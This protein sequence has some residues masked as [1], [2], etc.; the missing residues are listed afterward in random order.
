VVLP[1]ELQLSYVDKDGN[2]GTKTV[3][4]KDRSDYYLLTAGN[5]HVADELVV[6]A[7]LLA[8]R[9]EDKNVKDGVEKNDIVKSLIQLGKDNTMMSFRGCSADQYLVTVL[10][11]VALNAQR[12]NKFTESYSYMQKTISNQR[13]S[14]SGVDNDEEAVN[15]TKF[16]Q[17]YNMASKMIQVLS[18][19]YDRLINQT[20]V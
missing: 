20:G 18:E 8:T 13:L 6:D 17:Q 1:P 5:V 2:P 16:Q 3:T 4:L 10:G 19:V 11:D 12:A 15:L 9:H 7:D 14:V